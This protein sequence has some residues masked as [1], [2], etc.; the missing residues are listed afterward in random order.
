[1]AAQG[2]GAS[3]PCAL[4]CLSLRLARVFWQQTQVASTQPKA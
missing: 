1:M 4:R 3:G 2:C